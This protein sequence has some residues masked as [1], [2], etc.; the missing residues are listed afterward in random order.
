ME[1]IK[2]DP[3]RVDIAEL[4]PGDNAAPEVTGGYIYKKDKDGA[5]DRPWTTA[6]GQM[7]SARGTRGR[8]RS[9]RNS[10]PT[11]KGTST[12]SSRCCTARTSPIRPRGYAQYIDV[13]S[14]IDNWIIVEMC[15]NIDGFRLSTYYHKDRNGKIA[16][17]P[18]W[19]YDLS[20]GNA[21]YLEG[22]FPTGWYSDLLDDCDYPYWRRLFQDPDFEQRLVDR[23]GEYRRDPF[24]TANLLADVD[25]A[26]AAIDEAQVR[27]F[28]K[29]NIL[30]QW[31][32]PNY[33]VAAT[34][35]DEISLDEAMAAEPGRV[36]GQPVRHGAADLAGRRQPGT[37]H[38]G[39]DRL[40]RPAR[41]T[42][43]WTART[44]GRP[45]AACRRRLAGTPARSR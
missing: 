11:W 31:V 25:A 7:A 14:F 18:I 5:G 29:W 44:R 12:S 20:L 24:S 34:W 30:G 43:R 19:D 26:A 1:K 17:G 41:S 4:T 13:D 28:Q 39:D 3:N 9:R 40:H 6:Y 15:K 42:T 21:D 22:G 38:A 23:W 36:D 27:N 10:R 35:Q 8:A 2:R 33:Y 45:A 37:R 32:W 16:M